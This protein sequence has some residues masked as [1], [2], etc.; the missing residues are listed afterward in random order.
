VNEL[1]E[2]A[3]RG[4]PDSNAGGHVPSA[5]ARFPK[6]ELLR[7]RSQLLDCFERMH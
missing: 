6:R 3:V 2:C 1:L 5:G 4:I 7:F